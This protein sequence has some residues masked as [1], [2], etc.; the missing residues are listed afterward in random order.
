MDRQRLQSDLCRAAP[1][2]G[3]ARRPLRSPPHVRGRHRPVRR[4]IGG[5]CA[6]RQCHRADRRPRTAGRR[7]RAGDAAGN[8]DPERHV[9]PR[10]A[11]PRARHFQQH[12]RLRA[13]H[14]PR[15]RRLHH[16]TFRLAL[17]V[18]DQPADRPDR[19]RPGAGTV[20]RKLRPGRRIGHPR[21]GARRACGAGAGCGA[22]CAATPW[23]GRAPKSW[24]R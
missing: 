2:R 23:V 15:H 14:R 7:R 12:H 9:R 8:G 11:R 4:C 24:P 22:C 3:R 19:D 20:A 18:L 17:G 6:R 1:D 16:R 13:D 21:T 10:G 5:L